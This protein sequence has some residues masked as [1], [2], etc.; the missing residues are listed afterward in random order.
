[1]SMIAGTTGSSF[2]QSQNITIDGDHGKLAAILQTPNKTKNYPLV[3]LMHGFTSN[4][5]F[6]LLTN[7]ADDLESQT[8]PCGRPWLFQGYPGSR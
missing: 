1:M 5:E 7:L 3:I 6:E 8:H 2:A 4:K